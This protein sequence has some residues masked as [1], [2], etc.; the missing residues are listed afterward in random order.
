M[1]SIQQCINLETYLKIDRRVSKLLSVK[2]LI[3]L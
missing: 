2:I 1:V 3:F